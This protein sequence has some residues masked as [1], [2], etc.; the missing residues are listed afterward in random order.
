MPIKS[1]MTNCYLSAFTVAQ[2]KEQ[3]LINLRPD[4][5]TNLKPE[6]VNLLYTDIL[7]RRNNGI[8]RVSEAEIILEFPGAKDEQ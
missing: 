7:M 5:K 1:L 4:Q 2:F 6:Q 8:L 3:W